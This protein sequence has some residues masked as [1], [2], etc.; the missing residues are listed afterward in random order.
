MKLRIA[1]KLIAFAIFLLALSS[2]HHAIAS[3][4]SCAPASKRVPASDREA[5]SLAA[6]QFA[7]CARN[8]GLQ[9][10]I[11]RYV[12]AHGWLVTPTWGALKP[13]AKTAN[14]NLGRL[15]RW[16]VTSREY[17]AKGDLLVMTGQWERADAAEGQFVAVWR[18]YANREARMAFG[19]MTDDAAFKTPLIAEGASAT[20]PSSIAGRTGDT[21]TLAETQ[22][23]GVCGA[24]G[25]SAAF[26]LLAA[27]D[28]KVLRTGG[29]F[30]GKVRAV[31]DPRIKTERWRYIA[32]QSAID[33][34]NELAYVFGR[35][36]MTTTD[37]QTE[38]G[39]Y[40]RV[41]KAKPGKDKADFANWHVLI[42]AAS[43]LSRTSPAG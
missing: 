12:D 19:T 16:Q 26:D 6:D 7:K 8:V 38:R 11:D 5:I 17:S 1:H 10:A 40:A 33:S 34:A 2:I 22:F 20:A 14:P 31:S 41:W 29:S 37:G 4:T 39:Y 30:T 27:G 15:S 9:A 32:Q 25:M 13:Q 42:D 35:Y 3:T 18:T 24:S 36:A 21:L 28:V 23:G 43:P